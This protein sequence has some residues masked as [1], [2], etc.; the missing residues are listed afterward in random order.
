MRNPLYH[1][2]HMELKNPFGI[3]RILNPESAESIYEECNQQLAGPFTARG[4]LSHFNV[5]VLCTTD[6]P[7][8]SLEHHQAIVRDSFG[9][10]VLPAFRPD[11]ALAI[12]HPKSFNA[13]MDRLSEVSGIEIS[14]FSSLMEA[15]KKRHDFFHETGCR[16][17][18]H[19]LATFYSESYTDDEVV[20]V[21]RKVREGNTI[22]TQEA[23]QY[24][25]ALLYFL[26]VMDYEKGWVQQYHVGALRNTNTRLRSE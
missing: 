25:S 20:R 1:W 2:T 4:L 16:V 19:G 23:N 9:V 22:D 12:E 17:S 24:K 8:D 21:F 7:C 10:K 6:D 13:Y 18:D 11:K 3:T 15:L 14:N 5:K 26:A